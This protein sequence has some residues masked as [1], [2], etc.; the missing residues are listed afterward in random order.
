[1]P[2]CESALDPQ[3]EQSWTRYAAPEAPN[4]V[5]NYFQPSQCQKYLA[6]ASIANGTCFPQLFTSRDVVRCHEWVFDAERTIVNEVS[7]GLTKGVFNYNY[8]I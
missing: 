1:M 8:Y 4:N 7:L 5:Q 6:N 2:E 3:F